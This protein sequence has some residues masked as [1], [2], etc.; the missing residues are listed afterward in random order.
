LSPDSSALSQ[1]NAELAARERRK[2]SSLRLLESSQ[3]R[4]D[5]NTCQVRSLTDVKKTTKEMVEALHEWAA[6]V[7]PRQ[8]PSTPLCS[9]PCAPHACLQVVFVRMPVYHL[10]QRWR[11]PGSALSIPLLSARRLVRCHEGRSL[12]WPPKER[13]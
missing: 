7:G 5:L 4:K 13:P 9:H 12:L 10:L 6:G 11:A 1:R 8:R 2:K 3:V